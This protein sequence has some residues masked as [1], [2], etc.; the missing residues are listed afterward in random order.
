[1]K[2]VRFGVAAE[3]HH[4]QLMPE[5]KDKI[6]GANA[7]R[8][9]EIDIAAARQAILSGQAAAAAQ[10]RFLSQRRGS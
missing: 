4:P 3:H 2:G 6:F 7:V 5:V 10:H 1:M 8:I 9:F